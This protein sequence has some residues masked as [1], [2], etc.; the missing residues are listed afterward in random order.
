MLKQEPPHLRRQTKLRTEM[1]AN[2]GELH[3]PIETL[4]QRRE[5]IGMM[6]EPIRTA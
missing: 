1:A 4:H 3:R 6:N 2:V 5:L